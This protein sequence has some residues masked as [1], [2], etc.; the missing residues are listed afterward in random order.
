MRHSDCYE[1]MIC[2]LKRAWEG[3][4][5][6]PPSCSL[7]NE[8]DDD[9]G[10]QMEYMQILPFRRLSLFSNPFVKR[11]EGNRLPPPT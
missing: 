10:N 4:R 6:A 8:K 9:E 2:V 5:V 7:R 3:E 1:G 11:N